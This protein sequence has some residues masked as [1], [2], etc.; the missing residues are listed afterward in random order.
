[1]NASNPGYSFL[2]DGVVHHNSS[3]FPVGTD[4]LCSSV[5]GVATGGTFPVP[6]CF[7]SEE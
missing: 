2:F 7:T 6:P 3:G 1:M 5:Q 4:Y